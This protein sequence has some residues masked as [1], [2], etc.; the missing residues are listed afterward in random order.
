MGRPPGRPLI[1]DNKNLTAIARAM[2][3][4]LKFDPRILSPSMLD[5]K[6]GA[7]PGAD[8]FKAREHVIGR[9]IEEIGGDRHAHRCRLDDKF[10]DITGTKDK[11]NV[12]PDLLRLVAIDARLLGMTARHPDL[13][14]TIDLDQLTLWRRWYP[15]SLNGWLRVQLDLYG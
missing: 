13:A 3:D 5:L 7:L 11:D 15:D 4:G 1:D 8:Y 10:R 9:I 14:A 6:G 2:V 12:A